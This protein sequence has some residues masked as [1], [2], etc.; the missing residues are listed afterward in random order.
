V[1]GQTKL[2][3]DL[4][5]DPIRMLVGGRLRLDLRLGEPDRF[6]H[7]QRR[8]R[9]LDLLEPGDPINTHRIRR[10]SGPHLAHVPLAGALGN[11]LSQ[12]GQH[13]IEPTSQRIDNRIPNRLA[14]HSNCHAS[15][16]P[17]QSR[18]FSLICS[19]LSNPS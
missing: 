2:I 18:H 11:T 5:A 12:A 17:D 19:K 7:L 16:G 1:A 6:G 10:H 14:N 4:A 15:H 8:S 9:G 13:V 3:G